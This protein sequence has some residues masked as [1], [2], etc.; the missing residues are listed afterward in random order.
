MARLTN[1]Q[2]TWGPE[3]RIGVLPFLDGNQSDRLSDYV[4]GIARLLE[5][6]HFA[7][8][9]LGEHVVTFREYDRSHPHPYSKDG[10][11]PISSEIGMV[12]TITTLAAIA[13][14][15]STIRLGTCIAILAQW[16]PVYFA[17]MA[18]GLDL[19]SNGR[20]I[21]GI[22]V[23]WSPQE[24]AATN[25]PFEHRG[26]RT[27]E[28]IQVVR[29]LWCDDVS[30]FE[31]K[32]YTLPE[33]V[34]IPK[35]LSKPHPSLYFGGESLLSLRRVAAFG[36]GWMPAGLTP[37]QLAP[38]LKTLDTLLAEH[39]RNR[40]DVD[41][42]IVIPAETTCDTETLKRYAELGVNEVAPE[43]YGDSLSSF[44]IKIDQLAETL[45]IAARGL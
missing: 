7:S 9:W 8:V 18:T 28:Y 38:Q 16:N 17:K 39:G 29:S 35:P 4:S 13:A 45:G 1:L 11:F 34:Q 43:V 6:R 42:V 23:G 44:S 40:A 25:T 10:T 30:H 22:G 26:A 20:F 2:F 37:E 24:Y 36:Q 12:D 19:L 41:I 3:M 14:Q 33:C 32:Y 31:G 27:N 15:T 21:A 5:E